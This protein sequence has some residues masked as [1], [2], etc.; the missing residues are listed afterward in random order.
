MMDAQAL[1]RVDLGCMMLARE[2]ASE[3]TGEH[4][5]D[6]HDFA[7]DISTTSPDSNFKPPFIN[8]EETHTDTPN[9]E[10]AQGLER[11]IQYHTPDP[12]LPSSSGSLRPCISMKRRICAT[13][14][15]VLLTDPEQVFWVCRYCHIHKYINAGRGGVFPAA[16]TTQAPRHLCELRPGHSY[17]LP[18]NPRSVV[19]EGSMRSLLKSGVPVPQEVA[20]ELGN[21]N[22]QRFRLAAVG[23][24]VDNNHPLSEFE[25]PAFR[26]MIAMAN[27][28]AE[29]ALWQS[30]KS[31]RQYVMRLY[32]HLQPRIVHELSGALSRIHVSFDEWT[33]KGGKRGYLGIVAHYVNRDGNLVDLPIALPQL[34][35]VHSG[36]NMSEI[37]YS[38][39]Q[40][41]GVGPRTIGYFALDNASNND[42]AI[43]SLAQKMSFNATHLH[44]RCG[45]HTVILIGQTLLW[46]KDG[47]AYDNNVGE[48]VA[49]DKEHKLIIE[50]RSDGPFGVLLVV[51]NF[52]KI[53]QQYEAFTNFQ[54]LPHHE[55]PINAT[56]D[57]RKI[58]EPVKP[59]VTRWN[60]FYSCFERVPKLQSAVNAYANYHINDTR[61][62]DDRAF[63][64]Y[65][66]PP[67][68]PP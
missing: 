59:V 54:Q 24:P 57:D 6:C 9:P 37:V 68:A 32:N 10:S 14:A 7:F 58:L 11:E 65:N 17:Q 8:Y 45:P 16:A 35:G 49:V 38:T 25:K 52:I 4:H 36:E 34:M 23:W 63:C 56:K 67:S 61:Q 18:S 40:K 15:A 3:E 62:K 42:T 50:W 64:L 21:F 12:A 66:Q 26:D 60:S 43:A 20:N 2:R 1:R 30:R 51:I 27:P 22:I 28:E 29:V 55:L 39:L 44:L 33:T 46:G 53:P 13:Q 19:N 41:F 5:P 48:V 31:V 47:D